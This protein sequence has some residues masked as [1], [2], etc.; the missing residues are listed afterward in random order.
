M[1]WSLEFPPATIGRVPRGQPSML[2]LSLLFQKIA[3][4]EAR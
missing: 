4:F 2:R 3:E 1:D